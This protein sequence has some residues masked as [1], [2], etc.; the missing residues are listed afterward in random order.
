MHDSSL[1]LADGRSLAYA[2]IGDSTGPVVMSFHG[3][4]G[5]R[6]D[7][8]II[9][10]ALTGLNVRVISADRPGYGRSS[11]QPGRHR[12]DWPSDVA[13]LAD[14][15]RVERFAVMGVSSGGPYAVACSGLLPDRVASAGI[16]CGESDFGWDGAWDDYPEDAATLM[17]VGSEADAVAWC[18]AHYGPDGSGLLEGGM[19][20]LPPAD[21]AAL[22]DEALVT[23]LITALGEALRQGVGGYAQDIFV[24][25]KPWGFDPSAIVAPVWILHG[26]ADTV[27]PV[28]HARHTAEVIPGARLMTLPDHGHVSILSEIPRLTTD[29]VSSLR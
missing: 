5:S 20:E 24:Q 15:L 8:A 1:T 29:L 22:Q 19:G 23:A 13:A 7:V 14:H 26:E 4:P 6:L 2:E 25:G 9:E 12:E 10:D 11:P 17:R 21:Q 18:E 28:S 16:V 3:A 27:V